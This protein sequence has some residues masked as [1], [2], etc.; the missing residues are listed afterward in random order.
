MVKKALL[1]GINYT[2]IPSVKLSGCI[3]DVKNVKNVLDGLVYQVKLITD[4]TS[5]LPTRKNILDE[6][7]AMIQ[8]STVGDV[9]YFH[10]SG[11]GSSIRDTDGDEKY[12]F[13]SVLVPLDYRT[14]GIIVDDFLR[15]NVLSKVQT[16]VKLYGVIDSCNSGTAFDLKYTY[17]DYSNNVSTSSQRLNYYI[18]TVRYRQTLDVN[19]KYTDTNG[20]IVMISGCRDNQFSADAFINNQPQGALTWAFLDSMKVYQNKAPLMDLLRRVRVNLFQ[21]GYTQIPQL[22]SGKPLVM[23]SLFE[24]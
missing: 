14:S 23:N 16:G 18:N 5:I 17:N 8:G 6:L 11:H 1:V 21:R 15:I 22:S 4:E 10:Y 19:N 7:N 2:S 20:N 24:L 9:L 3:N 12:G 13:D